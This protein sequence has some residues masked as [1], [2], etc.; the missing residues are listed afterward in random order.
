MTD[1]NDKRSPQGRIM[2]SV[3]GNKNL[4]EHLFLY[5][6]FFNWLFSKKQ[7]FKINMA[8]EIFAFF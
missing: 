3:F 5:W 2:T 7:L 6:N 1:Q 8:E 4:P